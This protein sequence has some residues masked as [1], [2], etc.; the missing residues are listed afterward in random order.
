MNHKLFLICFVLGLLTNIT[1]GKAQE[2]QASILQVNFPGVE[3]LRA[4]ATNW[5]ALPIDSVTPFGAGDSVRTN[6]AGRVLITF[7]DHLQMLLLPQSEYTL[8]SFLSDEG[9]SSEIQATLEGVAVFRASDVASLANFSL[10]TVDLEITQPATQF[11]VWSREDNPD[12]VAVRRGEL[13]LDFSEDRFRLNDFQAFWAAPIDENPITL[14]P[15]LHAS[16]V[17]AEIIGCEGRVQTQGEPLLRVRSGSGLEFTP[18]GGIG[19]G[20]PIT[21]LGVT[22]SGR[23]YRVQY[24]T[25][26]GWVQAIAVES[27]CSDLPVFQNITIENA[28]YSVNT[29]GLERA[30]LIPFFGVAN[31]NLWFYRTEVVP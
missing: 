27:P 14:L 6:E 1:P 12:V 5:L 24:L 28:R 7:A 22:E 23:W 19:D 26:F 16:R 18:M 31:D 9:G 20:E 29:T 13:A 3:I 4:D 10:A 15:P 8:G 21:L 2:Q 11:A 25:D 30:F 17:E